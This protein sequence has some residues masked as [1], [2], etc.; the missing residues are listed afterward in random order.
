MRFFA[1]LWTVACQAPLSV[2]FS[3][4]EYWNELPFP[5]PG[6]LLNPGIEPTYPAYWQAGSLPLS[7]LG[8]TCV[9]SVQFSCS[10]VSDSLQPHGLQHARPPCPSPTPGVHPTHVHRVSD[11][12]QPSRPLSSPFLLPLI[13]PSIRVFSNESALRNRWP[14][15]WSFSFSPSK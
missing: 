1:T 11:A 3:R 15:Y 2:G 4:Q 13:F 9:T 5:P 8:S 12:I 10:V 14:K 6:D 7:H